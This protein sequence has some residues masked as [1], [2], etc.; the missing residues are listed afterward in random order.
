MNVCYLYTN[1][2]FMGL[3]L[4]GVALAIAFNIISFDNTSLMILFYSIFAL[5]VLPIII[6]NII[7]INYTREQLIE[8]RKQYLAF[9][10]IAVLAG[11]L[12][13]YYFSKGIFEYSKVSG[14]T[15]TW[16]FLPLKLSTTACLN[17]IQP[18]WVKSGIIFIVFMYTLFLALLVSS[19]PVIRN[20]VFD[21]GFNFGNELR[22]YVH[23]KPVII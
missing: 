18:D 7:F 19:F 15:L 2:T 21:D 16:G 1:L 3:S 11:T 10:L 14:C 4:V 13:L 23:K 6:Y 9:Y 12:F 22:A 17:A 8:I 20:T 5:A